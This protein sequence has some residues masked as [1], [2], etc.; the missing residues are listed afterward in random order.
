MERKDV[1]G[2]TS[3]EQLANSITHGLGV[4]LS[5]AALS[6]LVTFAAVWGNAWHVVG[7]SV[8]GSTLVTLY[9][10]STFYH[11]F[12]SARIKR[13][14][15]VVDHAGIY[16]VIAGTYT[17]F[18]LVSFRGPWGWSVFG[19]MWGLAAAGIILKVLFM[20]RG[21]ILSVAVY[22][23]MGWFIVIALKPALAAIPVGGVAWLVAGGAAYMGGVAF[24]AW[25][26][27]PYNHAVW[28]LF[29]LCGSVCHFFAVLFYVLPEH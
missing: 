9:L 2:E 16:L 13:V 20:G 26:R 18:T 6:V 11:A 28:H 27:L 25:K 7:F 15:R 10:A 1:A 4:M 19:I 8:Y 23:A 12:R 24:Y 5:V 14:L 21:R 3:G 22:V 29:V 17:P